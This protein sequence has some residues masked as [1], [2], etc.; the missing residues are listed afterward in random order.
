MDNLKHACLALELYST[1]RP[2]FA[3]ATATMIYKAAHALP[4]DSRLYGSLILASKLTECSTRLRDII[5][6]CAWVLRQTV[7]TDMEEYFRLKDHAMLAEKQVLA[8]LDFDLSAFNC[9]PHYLGL[10]RAC[11][12]CGL[13]PPQAQCAWA[14]LT[15]R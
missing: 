8:H 13:T 5:N 15:K 7:E 10:L 11:Q 2:D 1:N 6:V 14:L 12:L 9:T 4:Q 3:L